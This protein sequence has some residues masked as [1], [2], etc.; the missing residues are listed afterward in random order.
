[1]SLMLFAHPFSSYCQK[2]LIALYE[3]ETAFEYRHLGE[4]PAARAWCRAMWRKHSKCVSWT[5]A[6]TIS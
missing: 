2:A 3:N 1:M 6:L 4:D 5:A